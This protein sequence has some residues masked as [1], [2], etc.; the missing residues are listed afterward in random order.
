MRLLCHQRAA[1]FVRG[2]K[3]LF[4]QRGWLVSGAV[5]GGSWDDGG[6]A[7]VLDGGLKWDVLGFPTKNG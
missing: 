7:M 1:N 3:I 6:R 5:L 2:C 4:C